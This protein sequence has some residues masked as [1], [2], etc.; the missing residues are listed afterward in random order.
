V[1]L[2][3][4][5]L[6]AGQ[7]T[8][9]KSD[10]QKVLHPLLGK[11][12]VSYAV[13]TMETL[14]GTQ[15]VLIVGCD[16]DAV[17]E[18]VGQAAV[19]IEQAEQ[20]GTGHAVL[21]ARDALQGQSDLVLVTYADMPLLT[22]E[23]LRRLVERQQQNAGPLAILTLVTDTPRGFGRI[24]RDGS[25]GVHKIVEEAMATPE[26]LAIR[27]LN[28]GVYCFD[29]EWLWSRIDQIPLSLPKEEYYLPDLVGIAVDEGR[30]V[31]AV[32]TA[33]TTEVLGINTRV[34]LAEAA[35]ALR[36]RINERRS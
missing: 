25:G 35:R 19:F 20:K 32:T 26:E 5:I 29:A 6:A 3:S 2:K 4:I 12:M 15:P 21:Q 36:L 17:R 22:V 23:T 34:H 28:A 13:E 1:K 16:A 14:T 24:V 33:D 27:E 11:P 18:T 7:G 9:M 10:L 30:R 31:E 8:R